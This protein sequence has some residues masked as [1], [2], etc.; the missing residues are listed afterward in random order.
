MLKNIENL[1]ENL[2]VKNVSFSRR[3]RFAIIFL[4]VLLCSPLVFY[5]LF[6]SPFLFKVTLITIS[7]LLSFGSASVLKKKNNFKILVI[8]TLLLIAYILNYSFGF[9]GIFKTAAYELLM[10]I[11]GLSI[12]FFLNQRDRLKHATNI[13]LKIIPLISLSAIIAFLGTLT[14][15]IPFPTRVVDGYTV[16]FNYIFGSVQNKLIPR[17]FYFFAEPSY[18]GFFLGFSFIFFK[19]VFSAK[20]KTLKLGLILMAGIMT[21]STTFYVGIFCAFILSIIKKLIA[22]HTKQIVVSKTII[23][24]MVLLNLLFVTK[25]DKIDEV[26]FSK[27]PTT[28]FTDRQYRIESSILTIKGMKFNEILFG[29]GPGFIVTDKDRYKGESNAYIKVF[30]EKGLIMLTIYLLIIYYCLR[31]Y[32]LLLMFTL[33]CLNSVLLLETPLF[34]FIIL[35]GS[36]IENYKKTDEKLSLDIYIK[37]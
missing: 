18:L 11:F 14:E 26:I 37:N 16:G 1:N 28:S 3:I 19:N 24:V 2:S 20:L 12:Y 9:S 4:A 35:L 8:F 25:L 21:I 13:Y 29:K 15:T 7:I 31:K 33:V 23:I 30:I 32:P 10:L 5:N 6:G 22:P 34:F 17:S 27:F 36:G